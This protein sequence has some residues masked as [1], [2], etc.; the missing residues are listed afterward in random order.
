[1]GTTTALVSVEEYL[2]TSFPDGDREYIDGQVVERNMGQSE[3]ARIQALMV[4]YFVVHYPQFWSGVEARMRIS[5]SRYRIPD[6]ALS[7]GQWPPKGPLTTAPFLVVEI[8]SPDDRAG[9]M[10]D[11]IEDYRKCGVQYIW[12]INPETQRATVYTAEG[13]RPVKDGILRTENPTIEVPLAEVF[14]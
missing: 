2:S 8:L 12:V 14:R 3:H 10:E 11:K 6:V 7:I 13:S 5:K 4:A 1:M 9:E